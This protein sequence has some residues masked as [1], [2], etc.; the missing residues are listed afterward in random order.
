MLRLTF[1]RLGL[2]LCLRRTLRL[3]FLR[4]GLRVGLLG[5]RLLGMFGSLWACLLRLCLALRLLLFTRFFML[6]VD[7]GAAEQQKQSCW[8]DYFVEFHKFHFRHRLQPSR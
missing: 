4:S 3:A 7:V 8:A 2:R 1:L 6:R 5:L